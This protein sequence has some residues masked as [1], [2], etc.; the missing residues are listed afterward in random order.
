MESAASDDPSVSATGGAGAADRAALARMSANPPPAIGAPAAPSDPERPSPV[1]A[2]EE[3]PSQEQL[4]PPAAP[5]PREP[6]PQ[7]QDPSEKKPQRLVSVSKDTPGKAAEETDTDYEAW[8]EKFGGPSKD[9]KVA[10]RKALDDNNRL[11]AL[12]KATKEPAPEPAPADDQ[13]LSQELQQRV[14]TDLRKLSEA[15][16]NCRAWKTEFHQRQAEVKGVDDRLMQILAFKGDVPA[17]GE[18]LEI[19]RQIDY[20]NA[21]VDPKKVGV[22]D[23]PL[24][25]IEQDR[26]ESTLARLET[27]K[28]LLLTERHRLLQDRGDH[29]KAA[30]ALE[31]RWNGYLAQQRDRLEKGIRTQAQ[32]HHRVEREQEAVDAAT[33]EWDASF[34]SETKALKLSDTDRTR[35]ED[36]LVREANLVFYAGGDTGPTGPWMTGEIKRWLA[37]HDI[38]AGRTDRKIA[39]ARIP[40]VQQPA[41]RGTAAE[42][43]NPAQALTAGQRRREAERRVDRLSRDIRAG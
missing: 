28:N 37:D 29:V 35:L 20:W 32:E 25:P 12:A 6:E 13:P 43:P 10:A 42:A 5:A 41:P 23:E 36:H 11:A 34:T 31:E 16:P 15:D 22:S 33:R 9:P 19:S 18:L 30:G 39:Q 2:S 14:D 24:D 4:A 26:A 38:D 27:R 7:P 17:G 40:T 1:A 8:L 3:R 21:R